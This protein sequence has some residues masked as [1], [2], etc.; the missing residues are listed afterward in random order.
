M[1]A[2]LRG[3]RSWVRIPISSNILKK[4]LNILNFYHLLFLDNIGKILSKKPCYLDEK[5]SQ[6]LKFCVIK[7]LHG[8]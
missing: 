3:K 8:G 5:V 4:F 1:R 7:F 2:S 6:T